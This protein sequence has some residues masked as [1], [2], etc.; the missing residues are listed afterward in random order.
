M[1]MSN[2]SEQHEKAMADLGEQFKSK[3]IV[4]YQKFDNLDDMYNALK[5]SSFLASDF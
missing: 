5:V 3:L 4:E 2:V 1:E